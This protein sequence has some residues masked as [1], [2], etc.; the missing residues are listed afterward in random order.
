VNSRSSN[1]WCDKLSTASSILAGDNMSSFRLRSAALFLTYPQCDV[2]PEVANAHI[3][4]KL[5]DFRWSLWCVEKHSDGHKHLHALVMLRAR[6]DLHSATCLDLVIPGGYVYHGDYRAA[7]SIKSVFDYVMKDGDVYC[8]GIT[9]DAAREECSPAKEAKKRKINDIYG[10]LMDGKSLV[11]I[12]EDDADLV[13]TCVLHGDKIRKL[14]REALLEK[15]MPLKKWLGVRVEEGGPMEMMDIVGWLN[16]NILKSRPF[17]AKQLWIHGP[18]CFGKTSLIM[19]LM[20]CLRVYVVPKED[21]YDLYEDGRYD[22]IVFDEYKHDKT[23]QF[24]NQFV[25]GMVMPLRQKGNQTL[26]AKNLPVIVLSNFPMRMCYPHVDEQV[27]ATLE[28][29]FVTIGLTR[30]IN[31]ILD[32]EDRA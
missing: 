7:R 8:F 23:I 15:S 20:T 3:V 32:V 21:F 24:M 5:K 28:R 31:V 29:R 12:A 25:D 22:L 27:F 14:A 13:G 19:K 16:A 11:E 1:I 10:M 9:V 30:P 4:A 6:C 18:T 2:L 17:A 26:K